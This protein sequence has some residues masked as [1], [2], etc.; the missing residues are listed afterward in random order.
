ME[1]D[2]MKGKRNSLLPF[3]LLMYI[4]FYFLSRFRAR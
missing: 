1:K 3:F 2:M 4:A